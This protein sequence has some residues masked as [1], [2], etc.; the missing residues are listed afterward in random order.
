VGSW[1]K[2][3]GFKKKKKKKSRNALE[4]AREYILCELKKGVEK[5][6]G[7]SEKGKKS[8][9]GGGKSESREKGKE[10]RYLHRV[11]ARGLR[12]GPADDSVALVPVKREKCVEKKREGGVV[13][14][15]FAMEEV[16]VRKREKGGEKA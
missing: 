9:K 10:G 13:F 16:L 4:H 8:L 3:V 1:V 14:F 5:A 11:R 15:L 12:T 2:C 7:E 6:R